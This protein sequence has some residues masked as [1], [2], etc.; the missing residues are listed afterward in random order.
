MSEREGIL[1]GAVNRLKWLKTPAT[2]TELVEQLHEHV[3]AK[4]PDAAEAKKVLRAYK[5]F[6]RTE[7]R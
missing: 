6:W 1:T 7:Y 4:G 5:P 2:N 3:L